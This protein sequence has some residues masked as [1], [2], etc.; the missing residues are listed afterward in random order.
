M[1]TTYTVVTILGAAMA[2]FSGIS[3]FAKAK[4]VVQPLADYGVPQSV[5]PL[6]GTLKV[7]GAVGLLVGLVVPIIGVLAAVGLILYFLGAVVTV[8]RARAYGHVP[9]PLLYLAPVAVSLAL[10]AA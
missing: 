9:F 4:F 5:W 2:G 8:L 3:V 6:L 7:L 10:C 1:S